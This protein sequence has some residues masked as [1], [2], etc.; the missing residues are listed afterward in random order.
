MSA[1]VDVVQ[2]KVQKKVMVAVAGP[3]AGDPNP[4]EYICRPADLELHSESG[5][6]LQ[7]IQARQELGPT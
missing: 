7:Q 4:G 6:P 3:A 5:S 2:L 1:V